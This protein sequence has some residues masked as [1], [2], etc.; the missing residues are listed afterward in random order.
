MT[1]PV[2]GAAT[3]SSSCAMPNV[4]NS[5]KFV[6]LAFKMCVVCKVSV[7]CD[8]EP[9][10]PNLADSAKIFRIGIANRGSRAL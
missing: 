6:A 1:G 5:S 7:C 4:L 8:T 2:G 3:G 9:G 10:D